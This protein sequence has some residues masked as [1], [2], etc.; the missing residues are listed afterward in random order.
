MADG[1]EYFVS[2]SDDML[3][4]IYDPREEKFDLMYEVNT[5]FITDWH[6]LTYLVLE[7]VIFR[8]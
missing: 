8:I 2:C 5:K 3:V 7:K 1:R 6:T 4:R